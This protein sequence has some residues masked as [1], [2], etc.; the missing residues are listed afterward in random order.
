MGV[1]AITNILQL[2]LHA[3][4]S[5]S[6]ALGT[7]STV[8]K[9]AAYGNLFPDI[10]AVIGSVKDV[11]AEVIDLDS[12]ELGG[13]VD[14][15]AKNLDLPGEKADAVVRKGAEVFNAVVP[16]LVQGFEGIASLFKD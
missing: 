1:N 15:V 2:I 3:T 16:S 4:N 6:N 12:K 10:L 14:H 11:P 5:T 7:G 9:L 8:D 13:L